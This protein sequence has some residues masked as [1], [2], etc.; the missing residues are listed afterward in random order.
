[1]FIISAEID[2]DSDSVTCFYSTQVIFRLIKE[3]P[4]I[5]VCFEDCGGR[6]Y[7]VFKEHRTR[8]AAIRIAEVDA[9]RRAPIYRFRFRNSNGQIIKG[10]AERYI[11]SV[12][13]DE[14][15][16]LDIKQRLLSFFESLKNGVIEVGSFRLENNDKFPE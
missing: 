2:F 12:G 6:D 10:C 3:F 9:G 16:P 13:S 1:V 8:A 7:D 15:I 5:V 11:I 4:E 14:K